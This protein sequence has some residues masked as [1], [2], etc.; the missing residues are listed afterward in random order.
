MVL[1]RKRRPRDPAKRRR[2]HNGPGRK[3]K[4][5]FPANT[6]CRRQGIR[7]FYV[8]GPSRTFRSCR[9]AR[10]AVKRKKNL[11]YRRERRCPAAPTPLGHVTRSRWPTGKAAALLGGS[12][13]RGWGRGL[14][15][16]WSREKSLR[17]WTEAS[18]PARATC[19]AQRGRGRRRAGRRPS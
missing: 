2:G 10:R 19:G 4:R 3:F 8:I 17:S 1:Q 7:S 15:Q 13:S 18:C 12:W 5:N 9:K 6:S 14:G 11:A 16:S